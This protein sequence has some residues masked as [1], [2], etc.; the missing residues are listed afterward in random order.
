MSTA[1]GRNWKLRS[2]SS[3]SFPELRTI[4]YPVLHHTFI[5]NA[6]YMLAACTV[7]VLTDTAALL[8]LRY[9]TTWSAT[10]KRNLRDVQCSCRRICTPPRMATRRTQRKRKVAE[11]VRVVS[12]AD[13]AAARTRRLD[14]LEADA[15][16]DGDRGGGADNGDDDEFVLSD[17]GGAGDGDA[18]AGRRKKGGRQVKRARRASARS[19]V[20]SGGER[21]SKGIER[22]NKPLA[23]VLDEEGPGGPAWEGGGYWAIAAA[24]GVRPARQLCS[25][26]G[27]IAPYTCTRCAVRFC[28]LKCGTLH[29][30]TRCLKFT[31]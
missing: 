23:V 7:C 12:A 13:L 1:K 24:P 30:E 2:L 5:S 26:C 11:R 14:A 31:M 4:V 15:D 19:T 20:R 22:W 6:C 8:L 29:E 28:S 21:K 3:S 27:N 18:P 9:A 10:T 17:D 16:D 25:V